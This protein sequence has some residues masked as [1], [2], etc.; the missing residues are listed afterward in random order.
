M[1]VLLQIDAGRKSLNHHSN[2][3]AEGAHLQGAFLGDAALQCDRGDGVALN[4]RR[5]HC[6]ELGQKEA[7]IA[8]FPLGL[9]TELHFIETKS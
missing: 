4:Q 6:R 5:R 8:C 9:R 2:G 3:T 1:P 7:G